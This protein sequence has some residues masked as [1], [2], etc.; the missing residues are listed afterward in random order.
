MKVSEQ[1]PEL[2]R[3]WRCDLALQNGTE[4]EA[5]GELRALGVGDDIK[6]D[7]QGVLY[8]VGSQGLPSGPQ[9]GGWPL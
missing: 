4:T 1:R 3:T 6:M 2:S 8:E 9:E 7:P 5:K